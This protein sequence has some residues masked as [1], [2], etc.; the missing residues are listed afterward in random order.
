M[1]PL[2]RRHK[3]RAIAATAP[4]HAETREEDGMV[5]RA[6]T[7][8][9]VLPADAAPG[10]PTFRAVA[11]HETAYSDGP[12]RRVSGVGASTGT[13]RCPAAKAAC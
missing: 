7:W 11:V 2:P 5:L 3:G 9:E 13:G 1:R 12:C 10:A 4:G 6:Q 8:G